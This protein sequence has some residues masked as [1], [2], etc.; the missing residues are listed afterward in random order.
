MELLEAESPVPQDEA[1]KSILA[2]LPPGPELE[3]WARTTGAIRRRRGVKRASDLLRV[4]LSYAFCNLTFK[5]ASAWCR[6]NRSA[7][8]SKW[9]VLR[10]LKGCGRWLEFLIVEKLKE[11]MPPV[12]LQGLAIKLIDASR[13]AP[14]GSRGE[15]WRIHAAYDPWGGQLVDIH[16]TGDEGGERLDRFTVKQGD[17]V[18]ADRTYAT[19]RGLAHVVASHAHFL[20]RT[21]WQNVPLETEDGQPFD[22]FAALRSLKGLVPGEFAVRTVPDKRHGIRGVECRLVAARKPPEAAEAA[23]EKVL[24][25]AKRKGTN[26]DP[27]TLEA[28]SYILL[29]TSV[30]SRTLDMGQI[31]ALY[32]LRWQIELTF[33]RLKSLLKVDVLRNRNAETARA[34]MA[35]KLLGAL[36][37]EDLATR[38]APGANWSLTQLFGDVLRQAIMGAEAVNRLLTDPLLPTNW[39]REP[40]RNRQQQCQVTKALLLDLA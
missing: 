37:V 40:P 3:R 14:E 15:S 38:A 17:L 8:L 22:L 27:R 7:D 20:V 6:A 11:R 33:K 19:R 30:D 31:L 24:A 2:L 12:P 10:R 32:R 34:A 36:L 16:I 9:A 23:R 39:L 26:P 29:L 5:S 18:V 1:W 13:V 35:A 25:E 4:A 21:N 28:C